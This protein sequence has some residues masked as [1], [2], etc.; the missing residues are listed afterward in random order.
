MQCRLQY[1]KSHTALVK[2]QHQLDFN[3]LTDVQIAK[4]K[5]LILRD[6][7]DMQKYAVAQREDEDSTQ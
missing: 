3:N 6:Q 5:N 4:L 1:Q 7:L 2:Y